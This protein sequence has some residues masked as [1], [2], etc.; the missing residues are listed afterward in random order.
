MNSDTF[1][2]LIKDRTLLELN[3]LRME[4]YGNNTVDTVLGKLHAFLRWKGHV[5]RQLFYVTNANVALPW[6]VSPCKASSLS[7]NPGTQ[8][9][10]DGEPTKLT[11]NPKELKSSKSTYRLPP[12]RVAA[13][14]DYHTRITH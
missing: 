11:M 13:I 14:D 6:C 1:D 3:S 5:Y 12:K 8:Q 10:T 2:K 7:T 9:F 4:A